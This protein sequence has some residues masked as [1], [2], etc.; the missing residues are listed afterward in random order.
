LCEKISRSIYSC[1]IARFHF[2]EKL[3]RAWRDG[4][5]GDKQDP[6]TRDVKWIRNTNILPFPKQTKSFR[7]YPCPDNA[8]VIFKDTFEEGF[9]FILVERLRFHK[10]QT[11]TIRKTGKSPNIVHNNFKSLSTT[12]RIKYLRITKV[13]SRNNRARSVKICD[14]PSSRLHGNWSSLFM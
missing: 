1:I 10:A 12:L 8:I 11:H 7:S 2:A 6:A 5:A 14:F 13:Y 4:L 9:S 3:C